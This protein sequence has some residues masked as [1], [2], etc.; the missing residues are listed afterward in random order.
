[1]LVDDYSLRLSAENGDAEAMY[2][3]GKILQE[4]NI[5][6]GPGG[7][8]F[9]FRRACQNGH[10]GGCEQLEIV[11]NRNSRRLNQPKAVSQ[12]HQSELSEAPYKTRIR[13][14]YEAKLRILGEQKKMQRDLTFK[15]YQIK[16]SISLR[17]A[18]SY[19]FVH[20]LNHSRELG[21]ALKS[22][23]FQSQ[24]SLD[25]LGLVDILDVGCGP[26]MTVD[27]LLKFGARINSYSG[28]DYANAF[29]WLAR[30]LNND[31]KGNFVSTMHNL[32]ESNHVGLI[33]MNHVL[34]QDEISTDLLK[35]WT[36]EFK[37][38]FQKGFYLLSIEPTKAAFDNKFREFE[39][40]CLGSGV[41]ISEKRHVFSE[42][43]SQLKIRKSVNYWACS[44]E[45]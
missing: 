29:I 8:E 7:A 12:D 27:A 9:W 17:Q 30:E 16:S 25:Q 21:S 19:A 1:M 34:N 33:V 18:F 43:Q 28:F 22:L 40:L 11:K 36:W 5:L 2:R 38:I 23:G 35:S 20:G 6:G 10:H 26:G 3:Y 41:K 15:N 45:S 31:V 14:T 4:N 37:R 39:K 44:V 42:S 24:S 32:P 13:R